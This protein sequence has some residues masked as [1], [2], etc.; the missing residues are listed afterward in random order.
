MMLAERGE[1]LSGG[2]RQAI[3]MARALIG[4][5]PILLLD[6]PTSA[7]D[8]QNEAALIARLKELEGPTM[9][10]VTPRTSLLELVDRVIVVEDGRVAADGG[11]N[12]LSRTT[13]RKTGGG[14]SGG[15]IARL[16]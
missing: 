11:K 7:I 14:V 5:P 12:I 8:V 6:E 4:R 15:W 13:S 2:Q 1:G 16:F 10:V 9:L 3:S